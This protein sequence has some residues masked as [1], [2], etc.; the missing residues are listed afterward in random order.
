MRLINCVPV[1]EQIDYLLA[2]A[3]KLDWSPEGRDWVPDR[4][5]LD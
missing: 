4:E 1:R 2:L 5:P 3:N